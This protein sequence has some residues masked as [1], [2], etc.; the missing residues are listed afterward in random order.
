MGELVTGVLL[1]VVWVLIARFV[2]PKIGMG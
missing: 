1:V 2:L